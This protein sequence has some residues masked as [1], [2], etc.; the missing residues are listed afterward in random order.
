VPTRRVLILTA[1]MG[2]GHDRVAA[3]LARRLAA[4]GVRGDV[5]DVLDLLPFRLGGALRRWYAWTMRHTPWVYAAIYRVF[6]TRAPAVSPL[7]VL[8]AARLGALVGRLG[9]AAVVSTFHMGAQAAGHLRARGRL[10]VPSVVLLTDF[11]V[12]RLW[13][14]PGNDGYLCPTPDAAREVRA[15]IGR[16]AWCHAPVVRAEFRRDAAPAALPGPRPVLV[17]AGSWGVGRVEETARTLARS[18]RYLPVVLCGG[19]ERLRR[20]LDRAGT[21]LAM[22]WRDDLPELMAAAYALV[23]NASGLTC[24]E[25]LAAGVPVICHRPIPGHGRDG[26]VAL[27]RAGLGEY[28]RDAAE[29]IAALDRLGTPDERDR[30]V[31]QGRA[32]FAHPAA[33]ALLSALLP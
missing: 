20:R 29:L 5:A 14:H 15:A 21:G 6:F 19:N 9:P 26:A 1:A 16:P 23:D 32:A 31:S 22:G 13:L 11:A 8:A 28:A 3:E 30:R 4:D 2:A 25:A 24:K 10:P 12:H 7:T 18:G 33:E 27:T 17:A